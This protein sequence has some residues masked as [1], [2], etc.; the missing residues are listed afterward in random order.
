MRLGEL[1]FGKERLFFSSRFFTCFLHF[2]S[3]ARERKERKG[4]GANEK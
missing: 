3:H 1:L 4:N 2:L